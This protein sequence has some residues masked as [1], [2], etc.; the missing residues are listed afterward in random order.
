MKKI[1]SFKDDFHNDNRNKNENENQPY[2]QT[3][4]EK[5]NIDDYLKKKFGDTFEV[6][7]DTKNSEKPF[8]SSFNQQQQQPTTSYNQFQP[9]TYEVENKFEGVNSY[10]YEKNIRQG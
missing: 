5:F 7:Y 2:K 4:H 1:Y 3:E 6:N 10:H 9:K 8:Y